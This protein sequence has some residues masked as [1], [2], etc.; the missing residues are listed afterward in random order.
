MGE[1][2]LFGLRP[3]RSREA[4]DLAAGR[5]DA[6]TG[7]DERQRVAAE[8][9]AGLARHAGEAGAVGQFAIGGDLALPQPQR[10]G[11][12]RPAEGVDAVEV[13][14]QA[15]EVDS[16]ALAI[17]ARQGDGVV[18]EGRRVWRGLFQMK[19]G[20][21]RLRPLSRP[22]LCRRP[23]VLGQADAGE[24]TGAPCQGD[25]AESGGEDELAEGS[26]SRHGGAMLLKGDPS[27]FRRRAQG[28]RTTS[29]EAADSAVAGRGAGR[30]APVLPP[31][32]AVAGGR[33]LGYGGSGWDHE[34]R[35]DEGAA[36]PHLIARIVLLGA[37]LALAAGCT[38]SALDIDDTLSLADPELPETVSVLPS[39]STGPV[40]D[41]LQSV[42]DAAASIMPAAFAGPTP[43]DPAAGF[44][45]ARRAVEPRSPELDALIARYASV[46]GI[47]E[48]LLRRVVDR[49]S[50][51]N[52]RARNGPYWGLMQI[53]PATAGTMGYKG[54]PEGLLD[55]ETN[56]MYAGKYLRGAYITA[57]G[58]HDLAVRYYSR[59]YYYDAKRKGLLEETGLRPARTRLPQS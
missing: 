13:E 27:R 44:A 34:D 37:L 35:P 4:A 26:R 9:G 41:A 47:P 43:H 22:P 25:V 42:G 39:L 52:P 38:T 59:G 8:R 46:H 58:N 32:A 19:G 36:L 51:F 30:P 31:H 29:R 54:P 18:H 17:A 14:R 1:K 2:A 24:A 3:S 6:V 15:G 40:V 45:S 57:D 49:E 28:E 11:V 5:D 56:L 7:H 12:D 21:R 23:V 16:L 33:G 48:P 10:G 55:A 20:T 53:L 50:T